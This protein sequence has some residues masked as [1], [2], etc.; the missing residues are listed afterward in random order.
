MPVSEDTIKQLAKGTLKSI[1][2][3]FFKKT[4]TDEGAEVT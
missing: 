3:E 4:V 1:S 2:L